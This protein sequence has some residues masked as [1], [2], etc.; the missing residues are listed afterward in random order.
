M[1]FIPVTGIY[2]V[3]VAV[4]VN[5]GFTTLLPRIPHEPFATPVITPDASIVA[6]LGCDDSQVIALFVVFAGTYTPDN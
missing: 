5:A 6:M 4:D 3:I 1:G 2:T